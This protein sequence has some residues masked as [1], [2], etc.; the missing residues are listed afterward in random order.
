LGQLN[1]TALEQSAMQPYQ[2]RAQI[3]DHATD[4]ERA[5]PVFDPSQDK[6]IVYKLRVPTDQ[7][8]DYGRNI[9]SL[10]PTVSMVGDQQ[11]ILGPGQEFLVKKVYRQYY[12]ERDRKDQTIVGEDEQAEGAAAAQP[13]KRRGTVTKPTFDIQDDIKKGK[14]KV[15]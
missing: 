11:W 12:E 7:L 5:F 15:N 2:F 10:S 13:Y 1:E 6:C 14:W 9:D 8:Q 3:S 4:P